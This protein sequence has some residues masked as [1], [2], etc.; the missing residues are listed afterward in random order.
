MAFL[1]DSDGDQITSS[2][3]YK[4]RFADGSDLGVGT[5]NYPSSQPPGKG[6]VVG[7]GASK[8]FPVDG[9][10]W[11]VGAI[12]YLRGYGLGNRGF[13][14]RAR[15]LSAYK[16]WLTNSRAE[17]LETRSGSK[18]VIGEQLSGHRILLYLVD[19]ENSAQKLGMYRRDEKT[20]AGN[21]F[22]VFDCDPFG[23]VGLECSFV[24]VKAPESWHE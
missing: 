1:L 5:S 18:G 3:A 24:K 22:P 6:M 19:P 13:V 21:T 9:S 17:W 23:K 15:Y 12:G 16:G 20:H 7:Y 8:E 11:S 10:K 2:S 14:S 4:I